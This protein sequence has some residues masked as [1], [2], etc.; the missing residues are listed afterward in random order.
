MKIWKFELPLEGDIKIKMPIDTE[1]LCVQLQRGTPCL[2]VECDSESPRVHWNFAWVGTG[3]ETPEIG[4]YVGTVQLT[5]G[6]LVLH[7]YDMGH[8]DDATPAE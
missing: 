3:H 2:W 7:L 6:D 5:G 1:M 8:D 4:I